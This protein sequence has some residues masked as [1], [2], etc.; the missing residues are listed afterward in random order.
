MTSITQVN[1][2]TTSTTDLRGITTNGNGTIMYGIYGSGDIYNSTNSGVSWNELSS[3]NLP[4]SGNYQSI[5]T[6]SDGTN[7]YA[8]WNNLLVQILQTS[9]K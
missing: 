3:S 4:K 5:T 8:V 2:F 1:T 9:L 6:N 7:L